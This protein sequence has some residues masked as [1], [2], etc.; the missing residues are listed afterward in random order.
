MGLLMWFAW[1]MRSILKASQHKAQLS[2]DGNWEELENYYAEAA[3]TRRPFVWLHRRFLMPGNLETQHALFLYNR[4]SLEEALAKVD[5]AI[6]RIE[7]KPWIFQS[8]HR[9]GTFTTL[10]GALRSRTLILAGLGRYDEA[11]EAA[12]RVQTLPGSQGKPNAALALLEYYCGHLDEVIVL[13]GRT[14]DDKKLDDT[15]RGVLAL[16]YNMKGDFDSARNALSYE[17]ADISKF[18]SA[19]GLRL[20][21]ESAEGAALVALQN[22]KLASFFP[23]A[24]LVM[25]AHVYNASEDFENA[26][27]VLNEAEKALG[28]KP[29]LQMSYC[30]ERACSLAGKQEPEEAE[31]YIHRMRAIA[32]ELPKRAMLW[33]LHFSTGRAYFYLRR[34]SDALAELMEAQKFVLHPIEKHVT[35]FWIARAHDGAGSRREAMP[36]Y[37]IVFADPIQ[38]RMRHQAGE[39]LN[40]TRR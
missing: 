40:S 38:S 31:K 30:R 7:R 19:S 34:F 2:I 6:Q 29:G 9:S 10:C 35:A 37:Q 28:P 5:Q 8:I 4:G 20:M 16:V 22:K 26:D 14:P 11:R 18:Y 39:I 23:P 12:A 17:P 25:L 36:Y 24:R 1:D 32:G 21:H 27:R 13:A 15:M 3:R 33:E